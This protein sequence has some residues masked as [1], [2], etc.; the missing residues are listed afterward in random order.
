MNRRGRSGG[1]EYHVF[2]SKIC[3][4]GWRRKWQRNLSV[5]RNFSGL[6]NVR[7]RE[8]RILRFSVRIFLH[9]NKSIRRGTLLCLTKCLVSRSFV[10]KRGRS[11]GREYHDFF[12]NF[13]FQG[14]EKIR[15]GT[16][17][18]VRKFLVSKKVSDKRGYGY[19]NVPSKLFFVTEANH[20]VEEL[21]CV[22]EGFCYRKFLPVIREL[23][24]FSLENL[25]SH[26]TK[27][28]RKKI[29]MCLTKCLLSTNVMNKREWSEK[30]LYHDF[31]SKNYFSECQKNVWR[32]LS[33]FQNI[34]G[35]EKC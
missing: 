23:S 12:Q 4:S 14:A 29:L 24:R 33:V 25:M 8:E 21:F 15:R 16:L 19:H 27:K 17:L 31:L 3:V 6:E 34:S 26:N 30:R 22:L 11:R 7:G 2:L 18:S 13:L 35:S 20:F 5:F 28:L 32:N 10:N 9:S 1:R